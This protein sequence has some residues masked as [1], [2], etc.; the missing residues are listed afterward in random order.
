MVLQS[1]NEGRMKRARGIVERIFN[2]YIKA[3]LLAKIGVKYAN[4]GRIGHSIHMFNIAMDIVKSLF[5]T[6]YVENGNIYDSSI[7]FKN[8]L[9]A[10]TIAL[11]MMH[12]GLGEWGR[13]VIDKVIGLME[14]IEDGKLKANILFALIK[15]ARNVGYDGEVQGL[16]DY[17]IDQLD[18]INNLYYKTQVLK[19]IALYYFKIG[20]LNKFVT[21]MDKTIDSALQYEAGEFRDKL[22]ECI[23]IDCINSGIYGCPQHL[24]ERITDPK[25]KVDIL[26]RL[27]EEMLKKGHLNYGLELLE[28]AEKLVESSIEPSYMPYVLGR[29]IAVLVQAGLY[30]RV[31]KLHDKFMDAVNKLEDNYNRAVVLGLAALLIIDKIHREKNGSVLVADYSGGQDIHSPTRA[32]LDVGVAHL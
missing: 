19:E 7:L 4:N 21:Y 17:A 28:R 3:T 13:E 8:M 1:I 22:L 16:I 27:S 23:A 2:P 30:D 5:R 25:I 9:L 32:S 14:R 18:K 10:E 11:H 20:D 12:A 6:I 29:I 26:S 15:N 31:V 24:A